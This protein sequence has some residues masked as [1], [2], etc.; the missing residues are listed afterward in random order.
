M[1]H[2]YGVSI[3]RYLA[4]TGLGVFMKQDY[5][6]L[7][8]DTSRILYIKWIDPAASATIG[9]ASVED[10]MLHKNGV[11]CESVGFFLYEDRKILVIVG[12]TAHVSASDEVAD[13]GGDVIMPKVCILERRE[14]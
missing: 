7:K 14:L 3:G 4:A 11:I 12:S 8:P 6:K 5:S 10:V 9:W 2:G 13:V 1:V